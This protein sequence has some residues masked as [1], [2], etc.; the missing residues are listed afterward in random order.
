[1]AYSKNLKQRNKALHIADVSGSLHSQIL[2]VIME[3]GFLIKQENWDEKK[4]EIRGIY[5]AFRIMNLVGSHL[6]NDR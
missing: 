1:M 5:D 3:N 4:M 6:S 2:E